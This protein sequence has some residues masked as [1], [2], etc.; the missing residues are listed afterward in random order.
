MEKMEIIR[1][2]NKILCVA[3]L[4]SIILRCVV[5]TI[6]ISFSS[7]IGLGVAGLVMSGLLFL[8]TWKVKNPVIVEYG[9]VGVFSLI[10]I[11][12]MMLFPCTTNYLMFFLAIFMIIIYEEIV[13]IVL[14]CIISSICMIVFYLKDPSKLAETWSTDAMVMCIVYIVSGMFVFASMCYLSKRSLHH[15]SKMAK[16]SNKARKQAEGLL[17]EIGKSVNVLG[18]ANG[19][20][21]SSMGDT[22]SITEQIAVASDDVAR[23]TGDEVEEVNK[24]QRL[25]AESVDQIANIAE[26]SSQMNASSLNTGK[27]VEKGGQHVNG[28][29]LNMKDL[30]SRMEEIT[31]SIQE[32]SQE[33]EKILE[34]LGTLD[35]ITSQTNLLSLNASIEAARAGEQGKG[36][37]VVASEIRNLSEN[38]KEF[39]EQIHHI[40]NGVHEQTES[41]KNEIEKGRDAVSL[42]AEYVREV[43]ESFQEI[44]NNTESVLQQSVDIEERAEELVKLLS[45][46]LDDV[47]NIASN[48]ENTSA[49]MEEISASINE[50][51]ENMNV[52]VNGYDEINSITE[53]LVEASS[54]SNEEAE[55]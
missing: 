2:K 47:N 15:M 33:N 1:T 42:C 49:A 3:F 7:V 45:E 28:L 21:K 9:M 10:S 26:F 14:Q 13:P 22:E 27:T 37:A 17:G 46:T 23:R 38:S 4:A 39:T 5:N 25:V 43:D 6:F 16:E 30:D 19:K 29:N 20:I 18:T 41:V 11:L 36:F 51:H 24:I 52:V 54:Q 53:D 32:L 12:C 40:L 48:V 44:S 31:R 50:L 8:L 34:I 35:S 55:G